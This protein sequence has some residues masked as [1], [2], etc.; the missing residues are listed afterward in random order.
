[1]V[2]NVT[3]IWRLAALSLCL[4]IPVSAQDSSVASGFEHFYNLEYDQAI[5]DFTLATQ[6]NP[7]VATIWNHLAQAILYRAMLRS[8][9]LESQ[10]F[11]SSN[12]FLHHPRVQM[13]PAEDQSFCEALGK[14]IE[15]SQSQLDKNPNDTDALYALG[16]SYGL[17][18]NY[19]FSVHKA[20]AQA[21]RDAT[22]ARN[23]DHRVCELEPDNVDARLIPGLYDYVAGSL[24]A[25]YRILAALTGR[26]GDRERGIHTLETVARE[27]KSNRADAEVLLAAV[28][29][30]EKRPSDAVPLIQDLIHRFPR[31][32]LLRFELVQMYGDAGDHQSALRELSRIWDLH[33]EGAAGFAQLPPEKI[34]YLEGSVLLGLND[35][36]QAL[37]HMKKAASNAHTLDL[38]S[39]SA[40]WMRLGQIYDLKGLHHDAV[41][42][43]KEAVS[44]APDSEIG[45][46]SKSYID[47]PYHRPEAN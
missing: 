9:A 21:L 13:S 4:F 30:R 32:Y 39:G 3:R 27:G 33:R 12:A 15:I 8:G 28:Y 11:S 20:W 16:T 22:R 45:K 7:A 19:N 24:P 38:N 44:I 35:L 43:Y 29:R 46:E 34:D 5:A 41:G 36:D 23:Y 26:R 42:A 31:A 47:K 1:M 17:R 2:Y 37:E 25:G 14:A 18:A 6:H 40:C 10:L